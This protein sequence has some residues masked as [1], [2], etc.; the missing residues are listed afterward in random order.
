M[1]SARGVRQRLFALI[2]NG[3]PTGHNHPEPPI[4]LS[5]PSDSLEDYM[6]DVISIGEALIDLVSSVPVASV[7]D[8]PAFIPAAGGSPANAAVAVARLGTPTGFVGKV[9]DDPFGHHLASVFAANDLDTSRLR[10]DTEA[11]TA[12][13]FVALDEVGH[14]DYVFFRHPSAD[15]RFSLAD[16]DADYIRSARVLHTGSIILAAE[17]SRSTTIAAMRIAREAGLL[18]SLDP[19]VRLSIWSAEEIRAVV[20]PLF[21]L[22]NVVKLS[23]EDME[24]LIG[25][26]EAAAG[27]AEILR[28]GPAMVVVTRGK[29]GCFC[30]T[31]KET[32]DLPG[33]SVE[34]IDTTGAGDAF[35][36]GLLTGLVALNAPE[37]GVG[38]LTAAELRPALR[39]A[40]AVGA[41]TTT[42][43]GAIP[44]LPSRASA[45]AFLVERGEAAAVSLLDRAGSAPVG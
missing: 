28:H 44:A 22:A 3:R 6:P 5:H 18:V 23:E 2:D 16:L 19:N 17:P 31:A 30:R 1:L 24:V 26:G 37:R 7:A 29:D 13:A 21:A 15:M 45:R 27:S 32:L 43:R 10:F 33:Y 34:A 14:P 42:V 41:L 36:G 12:L 38:A 9:G 11:R 40:N 8:A 35:V 20:L 39:L 25:T 4:P